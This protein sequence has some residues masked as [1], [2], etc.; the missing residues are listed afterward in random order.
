VEEVQAE[1]LQA[2]EVEVKAGATLSAI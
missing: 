2:V 1:V